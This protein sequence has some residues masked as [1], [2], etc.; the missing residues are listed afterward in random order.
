MKTKRDFFNAKVDESR[1]TFIH[2][3]NGIVR[4]RKVGSKLIVGKVSGSRK[5]H[6]R[7]F[8]VPWSP[9]QQRP[10][11]RDVPACRMS[12]WLFSSCQPHSL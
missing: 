5:F 11:C 8:P 2:I 3:G 4:E 1:L 7:K 9:S 12:G 10:C 6:V